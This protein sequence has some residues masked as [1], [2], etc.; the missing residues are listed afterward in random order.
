MGSSWWV[1]IPLGLIWKIVLLMALSCCKTWWHDSGELD[2]GTTTQRT[3]VSLL[4]NYAQLPSSL[5]NVAFAKSP[6]VHYQGGQGSSP[7][8][9]SSQ[10]HEPFT[11]WWGLWAPQP[12]SLNLIPKFEELNICSWISYLT[13]EPQFLHHWNGDIDRDTL[14]R[15]QRFNEAILGKAI[16]T[17]TYYQ[18]YI[19]YHWYVSDISSL[20]ESGRNI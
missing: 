9:A 14:T 1:R 6:W 7:P 12:A 2:Q 19:N 15:W 10:M 17:V 8:F 4:Q 16:R 18:W 3:K 13:S 11:G 5:R 20:P